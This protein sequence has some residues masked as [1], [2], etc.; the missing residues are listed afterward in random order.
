MVKPLLEKDECI[1]S[2]HVPV[3][4]SWTNQLN[5]F[6]LQRYRDAVHTASGVNK[7]LILI[8]L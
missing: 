6:T 8:C 1:K 5:S 4:H 7:V 3:L 2:L